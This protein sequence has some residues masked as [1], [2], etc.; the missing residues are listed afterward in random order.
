LSNWNRKEVILISFYVDDCLVIGEE[1]RIKWLI[2]ELK[3]NGDNLKVENNLKDS[4]SCHII[5]GLIESD[6]D[7]SASFHQ[8]FA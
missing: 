4:L 1:E 8:Q 3:R 7:F 2:D 5:D 6:H